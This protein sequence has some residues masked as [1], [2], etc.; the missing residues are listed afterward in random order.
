MK[1]S[2]L[3][4]S[5]VAVALAW[6]LPVQGEA[7][8]K[9]NEVAPV[10]DLVLEAQAKL[11]LIEELTADD[12]T[13]TEAELKV[14]QAA[15]VLAC[16]AQAIAEHPEAAKV[17]ASGPA[18]RDAALRIAKA[19]SRQQAVASLEEANKALKG[20]AAGN[21][22]PN[23]AWNELM[24]LHPLM[25]EVNFRTARLRRAVRRSR[26][27]VEESL[28]A[29]TLAVLA[30]VVH[31]DTGPV[32]DEADLPKWREYAT[33]MRTS[34]SELAAA[35]KREDQE[36]TSAAWQKGLQACASCHETFRIDGL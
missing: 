7:P 5:L 6:L 31:A 10:E 19:D 23:H 17:K 34:M 1:K 29:T 8:A 14:V 9:L 36:A 25:E 12:A 18:L 4:L 22:S 20:E 30:Q 16:M 24:E 2:I 27:P 33:E 28:H 32:E 35:L 13:Y 15:G 21:S 26:D 3:G 11:T